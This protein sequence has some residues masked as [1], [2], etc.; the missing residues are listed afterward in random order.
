MVLAKGCE[1]RDQWIPLISWFEPR[2]LFLGCRGYTVWSYRMRQCWHRLWL[3]LEHTGWRCIFI[4]PFPHLSCK[5]LISIA[6]SRKEQITYAIPCSPR[7]YHGNCLRHIPQVPRPIQ[8]IFQ[9]GTTNALAVIAILPTT[10]RELLRQ[11]RSVRYTAGVFASALFTRSQYL[12][13]HS[14]N[15]AVHKDNSITGE[16]THCHL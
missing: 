12:L 2:P 3:Q 4:G 1:E 5:K 10:C 6:N 16:L 13:V 7:I 14:M 15:S 8:L 11:F 9:I